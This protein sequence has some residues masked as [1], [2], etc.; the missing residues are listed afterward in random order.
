MMGIGDVVV[1][2]HAD[3]GNRALGGYLEKLDALTKTEARGERL[4]G[5]A[6]SIP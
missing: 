1:A 6:G 5:E 3:E 2:A 4:S